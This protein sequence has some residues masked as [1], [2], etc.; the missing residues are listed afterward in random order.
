MFGG[1]RRPLR[2]PQ[3]PQPPIA[4]LGLP[5]PRPAVQP[6]EDSDEEE[7]I[8]R[9]Q[10]VVLISLP[11]PRR[12]RR[13]SYSLEKVNEGT[14]PLTLTAEKNNGDGSEA[15]DTSHKGKKRSLEKT[16]SHG[17]DP[18]ACCGSHDEESVNEVAFGTVI[19]PYVGEG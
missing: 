19:L 1:E 12:V 9:L 15:E 18:R 7:P 2:P 8:D 10:V 16:I 4:L 3:P 17:H 11:H 5:Q 13:T 14:N 6:P